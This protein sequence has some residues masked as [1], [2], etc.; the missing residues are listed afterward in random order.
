[1]K[2]LKHRSKLHT[3]KQAAIASMSR[4]GPQCKLKVSSRVKRAFRDISNGLNTVSKKSNWAKDNETHRI[5]VR[6]LRSLRRLM[7]SA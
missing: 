5:K 2:A 7:Q 3:L 4:V 6:K 1:M